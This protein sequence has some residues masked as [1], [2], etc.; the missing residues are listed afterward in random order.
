MV[1]AHKVNI[2][3]C[4]LLIVRITSKAGALAGKVKGKRFFT[5]SRSEMPMDQTS[6]RI[7]YFPPE[8]RSGWATKKSASHAYRER[9]TSYSHIDQC[10]GK[11]ANARLHQLPRNTKVTKLD[12]TIPR[13][14]N[15]RRFDVTMNC[16]LRMQIRET[17]QNLMDE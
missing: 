1:D 3:T 11:G 2:P 9:E 7:V 5:S 10:S 6:D 12:D 14:Q 17:L 8:M 13:K 15:V 16:F 4:P